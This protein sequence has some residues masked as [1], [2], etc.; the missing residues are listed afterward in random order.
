MN[1]LLGDVRQI[2]FTSRD[3]DHSMQY[4]IDVWGIGPWYVTRD[5]NSTREFRGASREMSMSVALSSS[6]DLQF[7]IVQQHDDTPSI[8]Q[9]FLRHVP[10][11]LHVQHMAVW[12]GDFAQS[13]AAALARGWVVMEEG[14]P[15]IG[16]YAYLSHPR[17]PHLYL[18]ISDR[19]PTKEHFR[20]VIRDIAATWDGK[21][22]IREGFPKA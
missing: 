12:A 13:R 20:N 18:E 15:A 1:R 5:I 14:V 19:S 7:E 17:E 4:F 11:G 21:D 22:P 2:S 3:I 9:E 10:N 8:F 6:G 16:P